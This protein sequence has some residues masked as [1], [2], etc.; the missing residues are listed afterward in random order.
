MSSEHS[1]KF[2]YQIYGKTIGEMWIALV[3]TVLSHGEK[4]FD[5]GRERL[6]VPNLRVKSSAQNFPDKIIEKHANGAQLKAM[7]D[8][9]F[10]RDVI[11]DV[12]V[13]KSFRAGAKSYSQRIKDGQMVDFVIERLSLIPESKKAVIVFPTYDDYAAVRRNHRDDYLPCIVSIQFRLKPQADGYIL[14]TTFYSRSM[15]TWQKGHGNFLS[16]AMLSHHIAQEIS[17]RLHKKIAI[18]SLDGMIADGHI[19]Q[20]KYEE[21]STH[22]KNYRREALE[23]A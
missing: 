5:E 13:V 7:I 15:D 14:N 11:E 22:V 10:D 9:M 16:I 6:A 21:A 2:G 4:C 8:F 17:A 20:E 19:Y 23:M 18:G 1:E 12:D 3:E